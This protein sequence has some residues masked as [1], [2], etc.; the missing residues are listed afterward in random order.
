MR[1]TAEPGSRRKLLGL[2]AATAGALVLAGCGKKSLKQQLAEQP[3]QVALTDIEI[4][5]H[6][7]DIEY[8]ATAAWTAAAPLLGPSGQAAAKQFL[9]QD[10]GHASGLYGLIHAAGGNPD[11]PPPNYDLGNPSS[12]ADVLALLHEVEQRQVAAYHD[13]IPNLQPGSVRQRVASY[14]ANDAQHLC[15]VR[16]LQGEPAIPTALVTGRD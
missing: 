9:S 5:N 3:E 7:L 8:L 16:F 4:L 15:I 11:Q 10:L 6:L 1:D 13:A 14:F 2:A 12:P